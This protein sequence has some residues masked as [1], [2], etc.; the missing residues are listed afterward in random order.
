MRQKVD[1]NGHWSRDTHGDIRETA[2]QRKDSAAEHLA[3][4]DSEHKQ[5]RQHSLEEIAGLKLIE[6]LGALRLLSGGTANLSALDNLNLTTAS[7]LNSIAARDLKE[8]VGNIAE[9]IAKLKQVI[10]VED[11]GTIWLG[12]ASDNVLQLLSDLIGVVKTLA[13]DLATHKH[14]GVTAGSG[15]SQ[16]PE[17]A[18][19]Y[20]SAG[21]DIEGI[22]SKLNGIKA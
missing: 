22:Q 1:A 19:T 7:D 17:S 5:V 6:A 8:H 12:N 9:R 20:T 10:K 15:T 16:A 18:S 21:S 4:Y 3:D 14:L 2:L 11:G 13:E